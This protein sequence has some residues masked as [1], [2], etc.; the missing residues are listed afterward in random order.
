DRLFTVITDAHL[1]LH[2]FSDTFFSIMVVF[3]KKCQ[4]NQAFT[5]NQIHRLKGGLV[6]RLPVC[7]VADCGLLSSQTE[8]KLMRVMNLQL[9]TKTA[10]TYT[11]C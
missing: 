6:Q 7:D 3:C 4:D 1:A 2:Q 8:M 9:P 5:K 11:D 10:M